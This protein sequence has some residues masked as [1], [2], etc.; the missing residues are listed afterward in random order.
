M[1]VVVVVAVERFQ[2][3][4]QHEVLGL[5]VLTGFQSIPATPT[6]TNGSSE[7][8]TGLFLLSSSFRGLGLG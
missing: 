1:L 5:N 3:C 7:E 8:L 6:S 2:E 4:K